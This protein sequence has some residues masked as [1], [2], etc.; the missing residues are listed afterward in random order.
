MVGSGIFRFYNRI[1]ILVGPR[2]G[3]GRN[4]IRGG[5]GVVNG[6]FGC[7][8]GPMD[9][10]YTRGAI[11][12][13]GGWS[14][15]VFHLTLSKLVFKF[16]TYH[17]TSFYTFCWARYRCF[18]VFYGIAQGIGVLCSFFRWIVR[19]LLGVYWYVCNDGS[20]YNVIDH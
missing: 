17:D 15:S 13:G 16:S 9:V 3:I 7:G 20:V 18:I 5:V 4:P 12:R 6:A 2:G 10:G 1:P 14:S 11:I 8:N 19:F